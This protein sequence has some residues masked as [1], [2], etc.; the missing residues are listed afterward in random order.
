MMW[1][2]HTRVFF[3]REQPEY[4]PYISVERISGPFSGSFYVMT[5]YGDYEIMIPFVTGKIELPEEIH[6]VYGECGDPTC[7]ENGGVII[8]LKNIENDFWK[9]PRPVALEQDKVARLFIL[10]TLRGVIELL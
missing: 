6:I 5:L 3:I 9:M 4:M 10:L 8:K 7:Y 2:D 1:N